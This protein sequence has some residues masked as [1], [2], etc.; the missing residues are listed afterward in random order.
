MARSSHGHSQQVPPFLE[1]HL[2]VTE[3]GYRSIGIDD[4]SFETAVVILQ[5]AEEQQSDLLFIG[6]RSEF[7]LGVH[8]LRFRLLVIEPLPQVGLGP[9]TSADRLELLV[10]ALQVD[11]SLDQDLFDFED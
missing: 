3:S 7:A 5:A 10:V 4:T 8:T 2:D 11:V 9:F 1:L 6:S